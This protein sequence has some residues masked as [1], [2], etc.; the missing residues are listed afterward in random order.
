MRPDLRSAFVLRV[1][2]CQIAILPFLVAGI[3]FLGGDSSALLSGRRHALRRLVALFE[4]WVLLI[5][6]NRD[7]PLNPGTELFFMPVSRYLGPQ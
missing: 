5:E 6:I 4:A 3:T 7:G 2:L 1:V